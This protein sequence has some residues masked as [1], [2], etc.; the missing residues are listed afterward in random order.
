[1]CG[2][3]LAQQPV[4]ILLW[5][6]DARW[7]C[8]SD[9]VMENGGWAGRGWRGGM[10]SLCLQR[11]EGRTDDSSCFGSNHLTHAERHS[12]VHKAGAQH[13][14][15]VCSVCVCVCVCVCACSGAHLS[16]KGEVYKCLNKESVS[17][18][19]ILQCNS[20]QFSR[21]QLS[22]T[23]WLPCPSPAPRTCSD[24]CPSSQ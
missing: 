3:L 8:C 16:M 4:S 10:T 6:V 13:C 15:C 11:T 18:S 7:Q 22:A 19:R 20:V 5:P 12:C 14:T 17:L 9:H 2:R 1:M 24:S 23:P 21:V